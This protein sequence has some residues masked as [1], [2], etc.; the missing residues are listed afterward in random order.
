MRLTTALTVLLAGLLAGC[1]SAAPLATSTQAAASV[2]GDA[3]EW[4]GA[5]RPVPGEPG[6]SLGLRHSADALTVVVVAGSE[7]QARRIATGGMTL[8]LD[9]GGGTARRA[10]LRFPLGADGAPGSAPGE[11]PADDALLRAVFAASTQRLATV[12]GADVRES[13]LGG[14]PGVAT[15]AAWTVAGLT[16]EARLPLRGPAAVAFAGEAS[17]ERVGLGIELAE[18]PRAGASAA[19]SLT[20]RGA[21]G[22][23]DAYGADRRGGET[24]AP[25]DAAAASAAAG[26]R[27]TWLGVALAP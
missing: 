12:R 7:A 3:G 27:T 5:L 19:P 10:G 17:A 2:D 21:D 9:P 11:P 23:L 4:A 16:V 1:R 8:W 14:V 18:T 15:A 6:L 20:G 25:Q 24:A 26:T 13:S 22:R